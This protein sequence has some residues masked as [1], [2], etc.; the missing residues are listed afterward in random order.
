MKSKLNQS[1]NPLMDT[2]DL[3]HLQE[4]ELRS[5]LINRS[6]RIKNTNTEKTATTQSRRGGYH[7]K[8]LRKKLN[9][10]L[11]FG[12]IEQPGQK[13]ADLRPNRGKTIGNRLGIQMTPR[14]SVMSGKNRQPQ[15]QTNPVAKLQE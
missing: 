1:V 15:G 5:R 6:H 11:Q 13:Q 12:L 8:R 7:K 2:F 4:M 10:L 9:K 14:S 3:L